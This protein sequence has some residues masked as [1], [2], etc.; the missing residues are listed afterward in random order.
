MATPE[1]PLNGANLA[2]V[3]SLF[4]ASRTRSTNS[5]RAYRVRGHMLANLD[6]L[7]AAGPSGARLRVP[8]LG[9]QFM[10]IDDIDD[11]EI[12][13]WL[14]AEMERTRNHTT[15]T[16]EQQL[17]ILTKLTDAEIFEQFL[18][19]KFIGA[20]RFS[21][22]GGESVIPLLD[23]LIERGAEHGVDEVVIGMAHRGR[24]NVLATSSARTCADLCV[25]FED[26]DPRCTSV[27]AT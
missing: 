15:L 22:E 12:K 9:V 17:R 25:S 6:G 23:L 19:T 18:H 11:L 27:A 5:S 21:L 16:R 8:G 24:L 20:K 7:H 3:E 13:T 14:Q 4:A 1:G 2:F 10:H 26:K